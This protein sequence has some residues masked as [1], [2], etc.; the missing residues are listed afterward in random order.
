MAPAS[1]FSKPLVCVWNVYFETFFCTSSSIHQLTQPP[2][3][4]H[5]ATQVWAPLQPCLEFNLSLNTTPGP[6]APHW[7]TSPPTSLPS[8][9]DSPAGVLW[10]PA[11]A[12]SIVEL[13]INLST[14]NLCLAV[15][16]WVLPRTTKCNS[17]VSATFSH[18]TDNVSHAWV[19][20]SLSTALLPSSLFFTY[21]TLLGKWHTLYFVHTQ[22]S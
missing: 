11:N 15:C 1:C 5:A 7:A 10:H 20:V 14:L 17:F 13:F 3:A 9:M 6:A 16:F 19:R 4:P 2:V 21:Q 8:P 12:Y 18:V 22:H